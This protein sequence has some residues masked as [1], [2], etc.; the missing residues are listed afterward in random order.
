MLRKAEEAFGTTPDRDVPS[1]TTQIVAYDEKWS[2]NPSAEDYLVHGY[3]GLI[4][5]VQEAFD[6]T[7][8]RYVTS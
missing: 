3:V 5:K 2:A 4:G 8:S 7:P 6:T 1:W